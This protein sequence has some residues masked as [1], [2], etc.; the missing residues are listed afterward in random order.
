MK[1]GL[2]IL[3]G[4]ILVGVP[5]LWIS[6]AGGKVAS[7]AAVPVPNP[8]WVN[9][10]Q[11]KTGKTPSG[12]GVIVNAGRREWTGVAGI[13]CWE[14]YIPTKA[15]PGLLTCRRSLT[16]RMRLFFSRTSPLLCATASGGT[17]RAGVT[18]SPFIPATASRV[19]EGRLPF[20]PAP[21]LLPT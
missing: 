4:L 12:S 21:T 15:P 7:S 6:A 17:F 20:T 19:S 9:V 2:L 8:G 14:S 11:R 16:G 3:F 5:R 13:K 1:M 10:F 18:E